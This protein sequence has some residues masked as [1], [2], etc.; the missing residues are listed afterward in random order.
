MP[1]P[2]SGGIALIQL[3]T[4]RAGYPVQDWDYKSVVTTHLM[5]EAERRVYADRARH[6]GDPAFYKVSVAG[7]LNTTYIK[8]RITNFS[9]V[10][11]TSSKAVTPGVPAPPESPNTTHYAIVDA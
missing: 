1:P 8:N 3:L 5:I 11:A 10:K 2:S 6:L 9:P 7:L 4:I